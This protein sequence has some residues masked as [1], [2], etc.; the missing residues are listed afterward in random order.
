MT[1]K[2]ELK[3]REDIICD[4]VQIFN[5]FNDFLKCNQLKILP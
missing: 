1:H 3:V 5:I 4:H 2:Y